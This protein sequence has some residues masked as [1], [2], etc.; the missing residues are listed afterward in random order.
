MYFQEQATALATAGAEVELL[1]YASG[2]SSEHAGR[3]PTPFRHPPARAMDRARPIA[4]RSVVGENPLADLALASTLHR[5]VGSRRGNDGFDAV[6]AHNAEA[7]LAALI[8]LRRDSPARIYCVHTLLGQELSTY[9]KAPEIKGQF[10]DDTPRLAEPAGWIASAAASTAR[11]PAARM[12]GSPSVRQ[13][14]E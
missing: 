5:V 2:A 14:I 6:L 9:L 8:G 11:S 7:C 10:H 3:A 12:A 1:T 13:R 4:L